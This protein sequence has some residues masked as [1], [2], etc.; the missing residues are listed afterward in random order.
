VACTRGERLPRLRRTAVPERLFPPWSNTVLR[1]ALVLLGLTVLV[2]AALPMFWVRTPYVTGEAQQV[3][4]PVKFDHRHHSRD[5]GVDCLYCHENALRS[6]HAGVPATSRCMGCH[7]QI[8]TGSPE[9][10]VVRASFFE[11]RPISWRRVTRLPKFVFFDHSIHLAKGVGCVECHGRVDHMAEVAQARPLT[12]AWCLGCHREP[13]P[14][15][16]PPDR[17]TDMDYEPTMQ[18]RRKVAAAMDVRSL[19]S[20]STCHR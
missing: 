7:A 8:W 20:C 16:R 2:G 14:H 19:T 6:P 13:V 3:D 18:E 5:D 9:L 15:L 11:S 12:M 10:E 17:V 4:Q 1:I